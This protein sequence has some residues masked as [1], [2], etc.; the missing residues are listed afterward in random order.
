MKYPKFTNLAV[1]V[2]FFGIALI[3]AVQ[4]NNWLEAALFLALGALSLW[5]DFKKN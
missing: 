5:A 1:F 4:K 3:E 2:I